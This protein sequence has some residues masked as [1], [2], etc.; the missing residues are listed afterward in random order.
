M[1]WSIS[2]P[3]T[4]CPHQ[5]R[6]LEK[7]LRFFWILRGGHAQ[8]FCHLFISEFLVDKRSKQTFEV[9]TSS[10]II[11]INMFCLEDDLYCS[12]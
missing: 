3:A 12:V 10:Q 7:K 11:V 4:C 6:F 2:L 5:G 1:T 8:I 9:F